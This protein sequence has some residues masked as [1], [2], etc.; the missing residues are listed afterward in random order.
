VTGNGGERVALCGVA[1]RP[2]LLGA[3]LNPPDDYKGSADYRRAMADVL[4]ARARAA[5]SPTE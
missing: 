3:E 4:V 5:L 1:S 2:V